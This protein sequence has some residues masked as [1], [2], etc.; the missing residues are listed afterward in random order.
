M[1]A[2]TDDY[3][4]AIAHLPAGAALR[5][6]DVSWEG[7]EQLLADLGEGYTARIFY[8]KG[9]MEIMVPAS[10]HEKPKSI[11]HTLVTALS[12][13]LD[14]DVESLGSTTLK[15]EIKAKGAEPDDSFYI[16][17][18][19]L[20]IGKE[21]LDLKQDPPP[22]LVVERDR[23]N[24]SLDKFPIYAGLG[25]PEIWRLA[26]RSVE[27]HLL[28]EDCYEPSETSRAFPFLS[29]LTLSEFLA[30]GLAEGERKAARDFRLW[31]CEH[32]REAL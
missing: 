12:D 25:I 28:V 22:D 18:A 9:R 5:I 15:S 32:H 29:A 24:A 21:D 8:D 11:L 23:T 17:N 26:R 13:E 10:T 4:E 19:R 2:T 16:Q 31:A 30:Q 1:S 6:D 20:V 3:V 27:I 14:I 7:Y